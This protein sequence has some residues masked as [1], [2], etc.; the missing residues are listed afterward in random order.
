MHSR[1]VVAQAE[2][3]PPAVKGG[4]GLQVVSGSP[5]VSVG[6]I[7]Y[8]HEAYLDQAIAS[9]LAQKTDFPIELVLGEDCSTD[10]TRGLV[11][12]W[13]AAHPHIIRPILHERNVGA[14]QNFV[15]I[16]QACRGKYIALLEGDDYW[17]DAHKLSRQVKFM[18]NHP[19]CALSHHRVFYLRQETGEFFQEF[20]PP[21]RRLRR[22]DSA[23]LVEGNFIQT[24]SL[25]FRRRLLPKFPLEFAQLKL[26]D[27]PLCVL[28][29]ERG[30]IGF[31]DENMAVYRVHEASAW[32]SKTDEHR[33]A[34]SAQ[35]AWVLTRMVRGASRARWCRFL[36]RF[37][38]F[39]VR[40]AE[41]L[42]SVKR[43][44]EA[45]WRYAPVAL[46]HE[47]A[48]FVRLTGC[49]SLTAFRLLSRGAIGAR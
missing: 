32:S 30:W 8:N 38:R 33:H 34:A 18:E 44:A 22:V 49:V 40:R 47:P 11:K 24:C 39:D 1:V 28:L 4:S 41:Q 25:L 29:G 16:L 2:K 26:G 6:M 10:G 35:M 20:P 5:T 21:E 7:T 14:G 27:W 15:E 42:R 46:V 48:T 36:L 37:W 23:A 45:F 9:I 13:A 3:E 17:T 31:L 19:D 43:L 12:K